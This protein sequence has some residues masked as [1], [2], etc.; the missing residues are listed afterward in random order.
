[1]SENGQL[2]DETQYFSKKFQKLNHAIM[3]VVDNFSSVNYQALDIQDEESINHVM[4][5]IDNMVQYDEY[6]MPKDS[7]FLDN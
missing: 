4:I 2:H 6:R 3:E 1:M 7:A 5:Q